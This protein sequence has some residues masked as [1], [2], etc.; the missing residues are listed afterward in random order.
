MAAHRL[1]LVVMSRGYFLLGS[2]K[3]LVLW[4]LLLQSVGSRAH[5]LQ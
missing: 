2:L 1:S 4:L 5:R 3:L